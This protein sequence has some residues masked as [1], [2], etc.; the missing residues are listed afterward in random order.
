MIKTTVFSP[1]I[2]PPLSSICFLL[3]SKTIR[4]YT[5]K[6]RQIKLSPLLISAT[7]P[8][9]ANNGSIIVPPTI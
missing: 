4:Q 5:D 2:S 8:H 6:D 7:R 1:D 9:I 3:K